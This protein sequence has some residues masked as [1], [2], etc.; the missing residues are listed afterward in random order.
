[1]DAT[2]H[3]PARRLCRNI[4]VRIQASD[5]T[6]VLF[7]LRHL[8]NSALYKSIIE[9]SM[10]RA[11]PTYA[12]NVDALSHKLAIL[13][14]IK[15]S[16]R[17]RSHI[18]AHF[19]IKSSSLA[20]ISASTCRCTKVMIRHSPVKYVQ[21]RTSIRRACGNIRLRMASVRI[22]QLLQQRNKHLLARNVKRLWQ[23]SQWLL[24]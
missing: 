11:S 13:S 19:V 5:L 21:K 14:D 22:S 24:I 12:I 4:N 8:S 3:S 10:S 6:N 15:G 9:G 18:N 7:A 16:T 2:N 1:M 17:V 20:Q 23:A